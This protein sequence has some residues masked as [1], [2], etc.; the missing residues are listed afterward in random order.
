MNRQG[1]N[2]TF[3]LKKGR[4]VVECFNTMKAVAI[5][6][7]CSIAS[8][9][10]TIE[11]KKSICGLSVEVKT[12][13]LFVRQYDLKGKF[14]KK[15]K[16]IAEAAYYLAMKTG[17]SNPTAFASGIAVAIH[18]KTNYRFGYKWTRDGVNENLMGDKPVNK[19]A[20]CSYMRYD[21]KTDSY[22]KCGRK[23]HSQ[24]K[25]NHYCHVCRERI[26]GQTVSGFEKA[27]RIGLSHVSPNRKLD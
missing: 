9:S 6:L 3:I 24:G 1:G 19:K 20:V 2:N 12:N 8:I 13:P 25:F 27:H 14:L 17:R 23:F 18:S 16:S 22:H 26:N 4:K 11:T 7:N 5:K 15:F 21:E 10:K